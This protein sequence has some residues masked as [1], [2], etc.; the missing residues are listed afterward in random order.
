M[1]MNGLLLS[2]YGERTENLLKLAT[3]GSGNYGARAQVFRNWAQKHPE[4][5]QE[6]GA[7]GAMI[8]LQEAWPCR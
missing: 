6:P 1:A 8:A 4:L 3:C 2:K 5:W 7:A